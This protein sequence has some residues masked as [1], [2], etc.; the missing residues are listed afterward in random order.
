MQPLIKLAEL[1]ESDSTSISVA[2]RIHDAV[3][4]TV[5]QAVNHGVY[6]D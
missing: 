1:S 3:L 6:R 2:A 4:A 5:E